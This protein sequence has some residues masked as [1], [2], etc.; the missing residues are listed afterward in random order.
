MNDGGH[1]CFHAEIFAQVNQAAST[2]SGP[3][4]SALLTKTT[5]QALQLVCINL[6]SFGKP[7]R[8][9]PGRRAEL[10]SPSCAQLGS[11]RLALSAPLGLPFLVLRCCAH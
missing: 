6:L 4:G 8:A 5:L 9:A 2:A 11:R 10:T 1:W 7:R 3:A